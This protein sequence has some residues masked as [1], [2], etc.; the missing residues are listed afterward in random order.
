MDRI[1]SEPLAIHD[2]GDAEA[3]IE[4]ALDEVGLAGAAGFDLGQ[5]DGQ[6]TRIVAPPVGQA[7]AVDE[8]QR[9]TVRIDPLGD[10]SATAD[11]VTVPTTGIAPGGVLPSGT[12]GFRVGQLDGLSRWWIDDLQVRRIVSPEPVATVQ[13]RELA[14]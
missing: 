4:R 6:R 8:W 10:L 12:V 7:P 9:V 2:I 5:V 13:R 3:R 14:P 1:L 11:G